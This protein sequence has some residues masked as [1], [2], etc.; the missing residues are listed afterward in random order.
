[1]TIDKKS[2]VPLYQQVKKY[3]LEYIKTQDKTD[4]TIPTEVEICKNFDVSR[5]T[6]RTAILELVNEGILERVTGKGTFINKIPE[7]LRFASWQS[8]EASTALG[9]TE[10]EDLFVK[11]TGY[12]VENI[13]IP[14]VE[15]ERRLIVM[16]ARG[17]APD[18]ASLINIWTPII[19]YYGALH[20]LDD[21]YTY[22]VMSNIYPQTINPLV[23]KDHV[24]GFNWINGPNILYYNKNLLEQYLCTPNISGDTYDDLL[25]NLIKIYDKSK[26][27]IIPFSIPILDDEL[28]FLFNLFNY[29][30]AF[31]GGLIDVEG[32][33]CFSSQ[34]NINAFSWLKRFVNRGHVNISNGFNKNR[35]LFADQ[36]LAFIIEGPWLR[37]QI[38]VLNEN[39]QNDMSHV[40]YA[41]VPKGQNGK[42]SSILW[43]H[44]LSIFRQCER[45][46]M[47]AEFVKFLAFDKEAGELYYR[48][49][50]M[51]PVNKSELNNNPL[52]NDDFGT[53]LKK[54]METAEP[55]NT[56]KPNAFMMAVMICAKASRDILLGDADIASTL[57]SHA[58]IIREI[59]RL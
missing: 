5:G 16:A 51:L 8:H 24:Y 35:K 42:S 13:E 12:S 50:G 57:N 40:G 30:Y 19:A 20:P 37:N 49:T 4:I 15:M 11:K 39:L 17:E 41:V 45:K 54:Q 47:A 6:V 55:I 43:S 59:Y 46:E 21:M 48:R 44:C 28:F 34:A 25:E 52:Y 2:K 22:D 32:E 26:G 31:D 38:P 23:Y 58:E 53:V 18:L 1:M 9:L 29:L 56:G 7:T 14:Y 36:K 27:E 33:L 10:L 3:L